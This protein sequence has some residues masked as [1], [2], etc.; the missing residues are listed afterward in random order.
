VCQ[1]L[2][3]GPTLEIGEGHVELEAPFLRISVVEAFR[4]IAQIDEDEMLRL[5]HHD[6]EAFFR[7]LVD[8]IEP[9][10]KARPVPVV[11]HRYPAKMASLARLAPDDPRYAERFEVYVAGLELSNGFV[12]LTNPVEQR[13]RLEADQRSRKERGLEIYPI[14]ERFLAALEAGMPPA[15]GNA[16]GFDRLVMLAARRDRIADVIAF[17]EGVL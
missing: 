12:E 8:V 11:L 3:V 2:G 7:V 10:L 14:D 5:A 13:E 9:S 4:D 16:L 1:A 17:P 15:A 6:E